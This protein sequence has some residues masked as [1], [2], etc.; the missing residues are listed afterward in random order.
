MVGALGTVH[1]DF[2]YA[3]IPD[4]YVIPKQ[5]VVLFLLAILT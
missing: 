3:F 4:Q 5:K 1:R 2:E